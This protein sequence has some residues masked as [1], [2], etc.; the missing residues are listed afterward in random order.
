MPM[1]FPAAILPAAG[2]RPTIVSFLMKIFL[3]FLYAPAMKTLKD[4]CA[5]QRRGEK[6]EVA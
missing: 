1:I 2:Q 5:R 4:K 6:D 3:T